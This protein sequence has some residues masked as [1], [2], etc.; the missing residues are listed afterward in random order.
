M[1][2]AAHTSSLLTIHKASDWL[3]AAR[4]KAVPG[5]LFGE[6]WLEGELSIMFGDAGAGKSVLAVQIAQAIASGRG[7]KPIQGDLKPRRVLYFDL[8]LTAKQFEMRYAR[9]NEAGE[10]M[11][12]HFEFSGRFSRVE[13]DLTAD[14]PEE[15]GSLAA[16]LG[17][18]IEQTVQDTGAKVLIVDNIS[19]LKRKYG[20]L[21]EALPLMDALNRM[22]RRYG[23]SILVLAHTARR[24]TN[25]PIDIADMPG[26]NVLSNYADNV[27]AVGT[28]R[29]YSRARYIKQINPRSTERIFS[30]AAVPTFFLENVSRDFLGFRFLWF[31]AE[32]E[33]MAA[34]RDRNDW[35]TIY[36]VRRLS[37]NGMSVR[38][39]ASTLNRSKSAI[40]RL[41]GMLPSRKPT[42]REAADGAETEVGADTAMKQPDQGKIESADQTAERSAVAIRDLELDE[43]TDKAW[44]AAEDERTGKTDDQPNGPPDKPVPKGITGQILER[45]HNM[46]GEEIWVESRDEHGKPMIW[47]HRNRR[48]T[49]FRKVRKGVTVLT[50]TLNGDVDEYG[51]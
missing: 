24:S 45:D 7:I 12:Q 38:D 10:R 39:I 11:G 31:A 50:S 23:M 14:V 40:H 37:D 6:F 3:R 27:F 35:E 5:M 16:Y 46:H 13:V 30:D 2:I 44:E 22:K 41:L 34:C 51:W 26:A 4:D 17:D 21:R 42:A 8:E 18:A 43:E 28:S 47:Y 9:E 29:M 48:G 32:R 49:R 1:T 15:Y 33:Q 20:S 25:R 19:C 36:R